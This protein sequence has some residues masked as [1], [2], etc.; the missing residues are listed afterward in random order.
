MSGAAGAA[1]SD[2]SQTSER[3]R[4]RGRG[5]LADLLRKRNI[6]TAL[7]LL[8]LL[9]AV[10]WIVEIIDATSG[11]QLNNDGLY[12]HNAGRWW[13]IF[14][15]PFI[16][17]SFQL[18][19]EN[20]VPLVLIGLFVAFTGAARFV[21]V[22]VLVIAIGGVGTWLIA[23]AMTNGAQ[24]VVIGA[25]GLIYGYATFVIS[26][27]WFDHSNVQRSVGLLVAVLF[28]AT[29]VASLA[30]GGNVSWQGHVSGATA[31]VIVAWLLSR[32]DRQGRRAAAP[33]TQPSSL[34]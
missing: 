22:T 20:T 14:T 34:V 25:S 19:I 5:Q 23:P 18:L 11:Y 16:H 8:A 27:G 29:L 30:P 7:A 33:A 15:A 24:E 6:R 17:G 26:R 9:V 4:G 3:K 13:G 31:G 1:S 21:I 28:G 12:P 2:R 32:H 10:M